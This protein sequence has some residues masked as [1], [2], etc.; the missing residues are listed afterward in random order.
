M[1]DGS[2]KL[3]MNEREKRALLKLF[4]RCE[5]QISLIQGVQDFYRGNEISSDQKRH[6]E[7]TLG[8][9][10]WYIKSS[11]IWSGRISRAAIESY[12]PKSGE[13]K[14]RLT[15][16]HEFPRKLAAAEIL[17][18]DWSEIENPAVELL[19]LFLDRY[20]LVNYVTPKENKRLS[21]F[22]RAG[23]FTNSADAYT[24]AAVNL[25]EA[26]E[27]QLASIKKRDG[28]A[29]ETLLKDA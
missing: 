1:N 27:S 13:N 24:Q 12:H 7:T 19:G 2:I 22:Q 26:S 29:I 5:A 10:L 28:R 15:A 16:D 25:I 3:E 20:G 6:L 23:T 18:R 9:G 21:K 17:G 11:G 8:A 14:P 4:K